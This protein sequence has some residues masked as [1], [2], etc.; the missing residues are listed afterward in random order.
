[1]F[2]CALHAPTITAKQLKL[3]DHSGGLAIAPMCKLAFEKKVCSMH[4]I[5]SLSFILGYAPIYR[6]TFEVKPELSFLLTVN[7]EI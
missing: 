3:R 2:F 6:Q 7:H 1:M 5:I 4:E